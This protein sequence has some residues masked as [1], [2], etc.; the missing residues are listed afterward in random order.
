MWRVDESSCMCL[1]RSLFLTFV[2]IALSFTRLR[3]YVFSQLYSTFLLTLYHLFM[4]R[5]DESSCMCLFRSL[6]LTFLI[7][8]LSFMRLRVYVFSQLYLTFLLTLY[9]LFMWRVGESSCVC[10]SIDRR[11]Y[12]SSPSSH[13]VIVLLDGFYC[14]LYIVFR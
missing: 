7:I 8:A 14:F 12:F 5:V 10:F 13:Y 6:F 3:V 11:F 9:H 4:W 1:F 2:I